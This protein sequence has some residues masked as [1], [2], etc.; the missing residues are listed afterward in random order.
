MGV[1]YNQ[2]MSLELCIYL[3]EFKY[4]QFRYS[5]GIELQQEGW[6]NKA[7]NQKHQAPLYCWLHTDYS[8]DKN[9]YYL[10][11]KRASVL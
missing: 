3:H 4:Q 2:Y 11:L 10:N 1:L 6:N 7:V 8:L 9:N 5:L